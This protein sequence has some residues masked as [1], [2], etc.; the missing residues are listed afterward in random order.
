MC[1]TIIT[2][3]YECDKVQVG[4][5]PIQSLIETTNPIHH[6]SIHCYEQIDSA[7]PSCGKL[8]ELDIELLREELN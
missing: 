2:H 1:K 7:E 6:H 4:D 5:N 3:F 8:N